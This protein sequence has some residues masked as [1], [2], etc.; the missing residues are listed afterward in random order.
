MGGASL[1]VSESAGSPSSA[2]LHQALLHRLIR[3]TD[4]ILTRLPLPATDGSW[5][6]TFWIACPLLEMLYPSCSFRMGVFHGRESSR[7]QLC[8][9]APLQSSHDHFDPVIC[10]TRGRVNRLQSARRT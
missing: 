1:V 10:G 5:A 7:R 2:F 4:S 8:R 9:S 3:S 6:F